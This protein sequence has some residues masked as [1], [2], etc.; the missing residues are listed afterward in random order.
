MVFAG[1]KS[2][3]QGLKK[4]LCGSRCTSESPAQPNVVWSQFFALCEAKC[5]DPSIR[6]QRSHQDEET[7]KLKSA[8]SG[9]SRRPTANG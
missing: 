5:T 6:K 4:L 8:I 2:A 7:K 9:N 1:K 3:L